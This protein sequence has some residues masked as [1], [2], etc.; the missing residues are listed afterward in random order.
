MHGSTATHGELLDR[1]YAIQRHFYDITRKYY[2]FGRDRIIDRIAETSPEAVLEI[3]C[4]TGRNLFLLERELP[5][6]DLYGIDASK[7]M[8]KHAE[9]KK[10][11]GSRAQ[12]SFGYAE[13]FDPQTLFGRSTFPTLFFSYSLSMMPDWRGA[14][15]HAIAL[16]EPGGTIWIVDFCDQAGYPKWFQKVLQ[17]WLSVF[18]VRFE[19]A[20]LERL[21][22][23]QEEQ[24]RAEGKLT[25]S[26]E[27]VGRR[28]GYIARLHLSRT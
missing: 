16:L 8:L 20:L 6:A 18:H 5:T 19:P 13:S 10:P 2:L 25:L 22:E 9:V 7:E 24:P 23:L 1:I 12:F 21:K 15:D 14:L 27:N 11:R 3:G 4:G 28:Y 17:W 26:F